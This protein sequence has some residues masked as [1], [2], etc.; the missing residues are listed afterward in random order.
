MQIRW[1]VL[2]LGLASALASAALAADAPSADPVAYCKSAGTIDAP[3]A[4]YKGPPV[5]GWML[6]KAYPP[7]AIKAQESAGMDPSKSIVWRCAGG[8]VL[9]CVQGNSPI[10]GKADQSKVPTKAMQ[11]FCAGNP[12]SDVIPLSVIGHE[13]P[14]VF[15]WSCHGNDPKVGRAIFKVDAQ[16]YPTEL[17][18][19]V[20]P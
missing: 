17:W 1:Q 3:D 18:Q 9:I 4:S 16:G 14:M 10:C 6:A 11:E 5:P 12:N 7:E 13:N 20:S 19:K 8:A 2:S 15:D